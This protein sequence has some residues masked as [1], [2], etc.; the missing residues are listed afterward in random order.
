MKCNFLFISFLNLLLMI[1]P[2][3]N[4]IA[5][6]EKNTKLFRSNTITPPYFVRTKSRPYFITSNRRA[7][8]NTIRYSEGTWSNGSD[9]GYRMI[10]GGGLIK[11]LSKHPNK[12]V[13]SNASFTCI[14]R[15]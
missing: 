10:F 3:C 7:F 13:S 11:S 12:L 1:L 14:K 9:L 2:I 8:L 15:N 5:R 4:Y 6:S